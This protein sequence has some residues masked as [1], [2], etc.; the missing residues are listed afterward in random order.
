MHSDSHAHTV[1]DTD[2]AGGDAG[3]VEHAAEHPC[4]HAGQLARLR[5][6]AVAHRDGRRDL[7]RQ[8][9]QRQVLRGTK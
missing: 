6:A 1:E 9:I 4:G 8:Q 3:I 7:P 5:H 2:D